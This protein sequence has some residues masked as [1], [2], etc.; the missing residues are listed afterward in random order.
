[1]AKWGLFPLK[2][3]ETPPPDETPQAGSES[4]QQ[5]AHGELG[6]LLRE[7]REEKGIS[8]AEIEQVTRIR[9]KYLLALEEAR[10]DDLPTPGHIHGF[11]RNYAIFLGLDAQE[12][13]ALYARDRA[14][15][16]R[17]E[18]K[19]FHPK[20]IAL[21]PQRP[22]IKADLLLALIVVVLLAAV[23]WVFWQY[24]WP[25]VRPVL[26]TAIGEVTAPPSASSTPSALPPTATL[27]RSAALP[28]STASQPTH[29][30][31]PTATE[32]ATQAATPTSEPTPAPTATPT[33][34]APLV[35]ATPT[36]EPTN[37]PTA[38]PTR[39]AGVVVEVNVIDRVWLQVT[40]DGQELPGELL[41]ADQQREWEAQNSIYMICGNAGGIEVTVNGNELGVLG[42]R[43]Q[44][45]EKTWGPQGEITPTPGA[46]ETP[47]PDTTPTATP[48]S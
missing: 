35:I 13:E 23:A 29:T 25:L 47:E 39:N 10:Y 33:L 37:T 12:V 34:D 46:G 24:G 9:P 15:Q 16:R 17:F 5:P 18:P 43:A 41:E 38:T 26:A 20:N 3:K 42:E 14:A 27:T 44:V 40:V 48:T 8:L 4:T 1:M 22:L 36:L 11:L 21:T 45:V 2:R 6:K 28:T 32:A 30:P 7:T 19:I 31:A